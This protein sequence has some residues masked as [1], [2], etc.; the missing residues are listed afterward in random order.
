MSNTKTILPL[1]STSVRI[2]M[3]TLIEYEFSSANQDAQEQKMNIQ[4]IDVKE[5][6]LQQGVDMVK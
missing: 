6:R 3:N 2:L 4:F 1:S 5:K